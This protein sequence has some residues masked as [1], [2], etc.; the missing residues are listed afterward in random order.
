MNAQ[1][2]E[3]TQLKR[4][5]A[6]RVKRIRLRD[7]QYTQEQVAEELGIHVVTYGRLEN[8]QA[9]ISL[10]NALGLAR[11]FGVSLDELVGYDKDNP[12]LATNVMNDPSESYGAGLRPA[13][14]VFQIGDGKNSPEQE[15]F[16]ARLGK[17]LSESFPEED[18]E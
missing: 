11:L 3:V 16:L 1:K 6:D 12:E 5:I 17:L 14:I 10:I 9:T 13:N 2:N 15:R 18:Q 4:Y 8:G 7:T